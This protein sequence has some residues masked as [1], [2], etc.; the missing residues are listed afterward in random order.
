MRDGNISSQWWDDHNV[1]LWPHCLVFNIT[2]TPVAPSERIMMRIIISMIKTIILW[3]KSWCSWCFRLWGFDAYADDNHFPD[4]G[5]HMIIHMIYHHL[6]V[7]G[8]PVRLW[9]FAKEIQLF[10]SAHL[11]KVPIISFIIMIIKLNKILI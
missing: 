2:L 3:S 4:Y 8:M 9:G 6:D 5:H 10:P 1:H 11:V 7:D